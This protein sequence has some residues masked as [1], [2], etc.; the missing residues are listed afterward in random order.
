MPHVVI[1]GP[2]A[3]DQIRDRFEP[4]FER[5]GDDI[6]KVRSLYVEREGTEALFD[7]L[8][9]ESGHRQHFFI[10]L[11]LRDGQGATARLLPLTDPEKTPGVKRALARTAAWVRGLQ[12][13]S[14]HF[15]ATNIAEFLDASPG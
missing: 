14:C 12:P 5:D 11:R 1:E 2:V 13:E 9:V 6:L 7:T 15:G 4:I 10:Q 8:V 3:L